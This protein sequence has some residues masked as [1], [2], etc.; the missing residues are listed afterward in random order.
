MTDFTKCRESVV[1]TNANLANLH[2][3]LDTLFGQAGLETNAEST[4]GW[5]NAAKR[6]HV[7]SQ[8][9]TRRKLGRR[10]RGGW[11]RA[12]RT[13]GVGVGGRGRGLGSGVAE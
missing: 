3:E 9:S 7:P 2:T 13:G 11:W 4:T 10:V 6:G 8:L 1:E 5:T 12:R